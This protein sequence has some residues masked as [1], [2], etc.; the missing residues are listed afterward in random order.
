MAA[1]AKRPYRMDARA[2]AAGQTLARIHAAATELFRTRP[3]ADVTLQAIAE[4]AGVTL[5][6]VLR[7]CGTKERLFEAAA[8]ATA[9]QVMA[10]RAVPAGAD[11]ARA[12]ETLVASYEDMGDLGWRGLVQEDQ[13]PWIKARFDDARR[14][15]RAWVEACFAEALRGTRGEER[16]RRVL[17]LFAATDFYVWKLYRRDLGLDRATVTK[18]MVDLVD[19][20]VRD[21]GRAR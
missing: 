14:R 5:Q 11:T 6:T 21:P 19:A 17:L 15:H 10:S 7:R 8:M 16:E 12:V 20:V 13:F 9:D 4:R 18:R 1:P 3:F 2:A